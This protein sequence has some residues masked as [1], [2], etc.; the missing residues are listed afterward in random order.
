L[1][2]CTHPPLGVRG[3]SVC[4]VL[5]SAAVRDRRWRLLAGWVRLSGPAA[6]T[7]LDLSSDFATILRR[8]AEAAE[9]TPTAVV[10][11]VF[12]TVMLGCVPGV[13]RG[14]GHG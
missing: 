14:A 9:I 10:G 4:G 3:R 2:E 5:V 7:V 6:G 12:P 8:G 1:I 11:G 13:G